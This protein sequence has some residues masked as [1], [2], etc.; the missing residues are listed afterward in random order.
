[1][2]KR[3]YVIL[4]IAIVIIIGSLAICETI[5]SSSSNGRLY[6]SVDSIPHRKVGLVLGTSP[7]SAWNGRRNLYYDHRIKAGAELYKAGKVVLVA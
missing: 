4:F 1:M 6:D 5:V 3:I 2:K 7:I